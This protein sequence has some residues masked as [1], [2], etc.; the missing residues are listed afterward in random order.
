[1]ENHSLRRLIAYIQENGSERE[2][3]RLNAAMGDEKAKNKLLTYFS[4]LQCSSGAFPY[5]LQK[6]NLESFM[7]T[8]MAYE[9]LKE[10]GELRQK[11]TIIERIVNFIEMSQKEPGFWNENMHLL[12]IPDLPFWLNPQEKNVEL[13][14]TAY[15]TLIMV[16]ERLSSSTTKKG[17]EYLSKHQTATGAFP[18][19]PHTT[20]IGG[21]ALL[22][23]Y[24]TFYTI[25]HEIISTID[26][27]LDQDQPGSIF[28]WIA[29]ALLLVGFSPRS[30]PILS[31]SLDKL[32]KSQL[33]NGLW[34]SEDEGTELQTT[35]GCLITLDISGRINLKSNFSNKSG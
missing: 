31:R 18:G 11:D 20:W 25:S 29:S 12:E 21:A 5:R 2:V 30:L 19:F 15:S 23:Y 22:G 35:V 7:H 28:Q 16:V 14:T 33:S 8:Y 10:M 26:D 27:L 3:L 1:M 9:F 13:L 32:E 24:G 4:G 6:G 17:I 34:T